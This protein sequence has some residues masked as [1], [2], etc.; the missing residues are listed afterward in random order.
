MKRTNI[1]LGEAQADA[2]DELALAQGTSRAEL[3][4]QLIDREIGGFGAA[5]LEAD[6]AAI[7]ESF[8]VLRDEELVFSRGPDERSRY[9]DRVASQ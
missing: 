7:R 4:R 6:L 1:Y 5:D 3:I 9:L 2:L 8:G